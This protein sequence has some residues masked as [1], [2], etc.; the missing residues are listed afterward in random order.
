MQ[1][2]L[3]SRGRLLP[4]LA[5]AAQSLLCISTAP[6]YSTGTVQLHRCT[7]PATGK[8]ERAVMKAI[9]DIPK[10][11]FKVYTTIFDIPSV[12][13]VF[14]LTFYDAFQNFSLTIPTSV[15][16]EKVQRMIPWHTV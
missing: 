1:Q 13:A 16:F 9:R 8:R 15:Q 7:V 6:A 2:Q 14:S 4:S 12:F 3:H 11:V 5:A 10:R